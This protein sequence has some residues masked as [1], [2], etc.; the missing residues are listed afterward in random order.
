MQNVT[1]QLQTDDCNAFQSI[2]LEN[3]LFECEMML[4]DLKKDAD[5][6]GH[7][8]QWEQGLQQIRSRISIYQREFNLDELSSI[9]AINTTKIEELNLHRIWLG[10]DLSNLSRQTIYQW[11]L[12]IQHI[13]QH[14]QKSI[15]S[16]LWIWD[17]DQLANNPHFIA[18]K[19][20]SP[21]DAVLGTYCFGQ[22]QLCVRSLSQA[23]KKEKPALWEHFQLL[24]AGGYYVNLSDYSRFFILEREGGIYIDVDT[25]PHKYS[26]IM[27][28]FPEVPAG[29]ELSCL[30]SFRDED[31]FILAAPDDPF[32][33]DM[34]KHLDA[35]IAGIEISHLQHPSHA[36]QVE[37]D[38]FNSFY[39]IWS[40]A[41][42]QRILDYSS[43]FDR[44]SIL[45]P[46]EREELQIG[47]FGMRV[48]FEAR[49]GNELVP[50]TT[51][52]Q[53][54]Y[55]A[56]IHCLEE[57]EWSLPNALDLEK[58]IALL[59]NEERLRVVYFAQL[60]NTDD[61]FNYYSVNSKDPQL[62]RVNNLFAQ[63]MV[64]RNAAQIR[65]GNFWYP[66]Q[67]S[68]VV[69]RQKP[70][71]V[72]WIKGDQATEEDQIRL[73]KLLYSTGYYIDYYS[74]RNKLGYDFETL[75]RKQNVEPFLPQFELCYNT[76]GDWIGAF[77]PE[78][79]VMQENKD[80]SIKGDFYY[81]DEMREV[82]ENYLRF[83]RH[84]Q[85]NGDCSIHA[86]IIDPK[87]QGQGYFHS[88]YEHMIQVAQQWE[89]QRLALTVWENNPASRLYQRMGFVCQGRS[90]HL[91][92]LF[93]DRLLFLTN[94][95]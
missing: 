29:I 61:F 93:F 81:R 17:E 88:M 50:L 38:F 77:R 83:L 78:R 46:M 20:D 85:R 91:Y 72:S 57:F 52:E 66:L 63:Y 70:H 26:A 90:E 24:Y 35:H 13:Y 68:P 8:S 43:F 3:P 71:K 49:L 10:G 58:H 12:L 30:N 79:S 44:Y 5:E 82:E 33:R 37:R 28:R 6:Q 48:L 4:Q 54:H 56:V 53:A 47:I 15:Q 9:Y 2:D 21:C 74:F 84:H 40:S 55:D 87:L 86:V 39:E 76:Q 11:D 32:M 27:L 60:R 34:R 80:I 31:G 69:R 92:P 16:Y 23:L 67:N 22:V 42:T 51:Q 7:N 64:A 1:Y 65:Q 18:G 75:Y 89:C 45:G 19:A 94:D 36:E 25:I 14:H 59:K 73:G 41:L 95:L 62:D